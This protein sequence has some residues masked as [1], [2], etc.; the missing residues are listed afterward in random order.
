MLRA[1]SINARDA[2]FATLRSETDAGFCPADHDG[3]TSRRLRGAAAP[4]SPLSATTHLQG[5]PSDRCADALRQ[6]H[7]R[8]PAAVYLLVP[9]SRETELGPCRC[10]VLRTEYTGT[11][12]PGSPVGL[13]HVVWPDRRTPLGPLADGTST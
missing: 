10:T 2:R 5:P 6:T 8:E 4:V 11:A 1:R 7:P 3:P 9:A 12:L 13:A